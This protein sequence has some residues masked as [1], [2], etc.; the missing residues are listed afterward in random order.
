MNIGKRL[1]ALRMLNNKTQKE[2]A[3]HLGVAINSYSQYENDVRQ[4]SYDM[5]AKISDY[6]NVTYDFL[7]DEYKDVPEYY[8]DLDNDALYSEIVVDDLMMNIRT[9]L[10]IMHIL[11]KIKKEEP[12]NSDKYSYVLKGLEKQYM[13][14]KKSLKDYEKHFDITNMHDRFEKYLN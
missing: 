10:K 6:Y 4:P 8:K 5:L 12:L 1:K 3:T 11:D 7:L 2:I 14:Y 13:D 9:S